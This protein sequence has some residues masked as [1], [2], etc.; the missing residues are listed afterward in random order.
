MD[1]PAPSSHSPDSYDVMAAPALRMGWL[2]RSVA[3]GVMLVAIVWLRPVRRP[4]LVQPQL[5][6]RQTSV[7]GTD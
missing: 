4:A 2:L 7:P 6:P 3:L 5:N 1:A